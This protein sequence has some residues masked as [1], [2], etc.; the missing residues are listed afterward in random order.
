MINEIQPQQNN[1]RLSLKLHS[2]FE[3]FNSYI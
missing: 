2:T 1:M 3:I